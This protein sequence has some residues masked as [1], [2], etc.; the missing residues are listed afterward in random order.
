[1]EYVEGETLQHRLEKGRLSLGKALEYAIQIADAL[2]KA[3]R[4]GVVHRD[5][6]PGNIMVA[7]TGVKLLD[8]GLAK[9]KGDAGAVS[10]P[11]SE[12]PT[13]DG[14][15]PLTEKGTILGTLQY[16]APE[17][18]EGKDSDDRTDIFA[19]GAV[20]YEMVTGKKAFEGQSQAS[21]IAAILDREP[22]PVSSG[23]PASPPPLDRIV[24]TC[25]EKDPADR[26][27]SSRDV[28]RELQWTV[29]DREQQSATR[30]LTP[31]PMTRRRWLALGG[32]AAGVLTLSIWLP[33]WGGEETT[34][35]G[36]PVIVLM[37]STHPLR[38]YD[39]AT[40]EEGGTN[41]DDLTNILRDLPVLLVKENTSPSWNREE[42]VLLQN[43][44][45]IVA[46]ASSFWDATPDD[47]PELGQIT[48]PLALDKFEMF[49]G[50]VGRANPSTRFLA[51]SR[52]K[53]NNDPQLRQEW[54]ESLEA[55]FPVLSGR[56][57]AWQ[58][59]LDRP[60]YRDPT[61]A[62]EI[63]AEALCANVG[64]TPA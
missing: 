58:V 22:P 45:I 1:M 32:V 43:P 51:Y 49:L 4:Q 13:Q 10:S 28:L 35:T 50:Y 27:Q 61:T 17:Q 38:I 29:A 9:L 18:L 52:G 3:H 62:S 60:T 59:P 64:E 21:L 37:D 20:V 16:M 26:W 15:K 57:T 11:M 39:A 30:L 12:L 8:F 7:K 24:K 6:K 19:F 2:D 63:H 33:N 40:R 36:P 54:V 44:V 25:L 23:L 14:S 46:H 34:S 5:L 41:A 48:D 56:V 53:W 31:P 47:D 42:E 55:R